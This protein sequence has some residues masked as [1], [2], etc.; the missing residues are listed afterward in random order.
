ML[1]LSYDYGQELYGTALRPEINYYILCLIF[2]SFEGITKQV[3]YGTWRG[4]NKDDIE[5]WAV[6]G[7][8]LG[9]HVQG[10]ETSVQSWEEKNYGS[11]QPPLFV[12]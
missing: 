4:A 11:V 3:R 6:S 10:G 5:E 8:H 2:K 9:V 7:D 12:I 1:I